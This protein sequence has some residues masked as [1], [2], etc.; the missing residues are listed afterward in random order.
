MIFVL[1]LSS[2]FVDDLFFCFLVLLKLFGY[3][4]LVMFCWYV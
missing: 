4:M 3:G 1:V 2:G